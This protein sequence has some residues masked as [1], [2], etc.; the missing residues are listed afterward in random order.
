MPLAAAED[1]T[2]FKT[3]RKNVLVVNKKKANVSSF[4]V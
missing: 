3:S 4:V 1:V 2:K